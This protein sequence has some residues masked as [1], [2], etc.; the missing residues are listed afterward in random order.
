MYKNQLYF[1]GNLVPNVDVNSLTLN[2]QFGNISND[3]IIKDKNH[4]YYITPS[5]YSLHSITGADV[6]SF[7]G[8]T[9]H[10][11][12]PDGTSYDDTLRDYYQDKNHLYRHDVPLP[13]VDKK[14]FQ[15]L[16]KGYIYGTVDY[17]KDKSHVYANADI[18]EGADVK[19][20]RTV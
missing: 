18:V 14:T 11:D 1:Y 6:K 10:Y 20:F 15:P 7:T 5:A 12:Y 13:K 9:Y 19:T 4:V 17:S 3:H 8:I 2:M 16:G